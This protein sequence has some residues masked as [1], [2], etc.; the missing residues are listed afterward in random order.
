MFIPSYH[1]EERPAQLMAIMRQY[2]FGQLITAVG[3]EPHVTLLPLLHEP[4][5]AGGWG[6][7]VVHL[8]RQNPQ[9]QHLLQ[10]RVAKA[11]YMGP[12]TYISPTWYRVTR[13]VPTWNYITVQA[14]GHPAVMLDKDA[15][16]AHLNDLVLRFEGDGAAAWRVDETVGQ[17]YVEKL[18]SMLVAFRIELTEVV[19][20]FKLNQDKQPDDIRGV[21]EALANQKEQEAQ[22]VGQA[23]RSYFAEL[24]ATA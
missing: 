9:V 4:D 14:T 18:L 12:H 23:M 22:A 11:L 8:H 24:F 5:P 6:S 2:P 15:I 13:T 16:I 19:G 10:G 7:L 20:N 21:V 1:K 17:A 3:D